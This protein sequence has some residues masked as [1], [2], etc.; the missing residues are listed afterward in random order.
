MYGG[1]LYR[2][3]IGTGKHAMEKSW[4]VKK[5]DKRSCD[6]VTSQLYLFWS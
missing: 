4:N 6:L 2:F 1:Y 5:V 3:L